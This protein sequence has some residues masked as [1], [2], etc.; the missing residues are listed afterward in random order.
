MVTYT[1]L[2]ATHQAR[3]RC[4]LHKYILNS[5]DDELRNNDFYDD[6]DRE[7][8]APLHQNQVLRIQVLIVILWNIIL[9]EVV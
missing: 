2:I 5:T 1:S 9:Q 4:L 7:S 3:L 6:D 8:S